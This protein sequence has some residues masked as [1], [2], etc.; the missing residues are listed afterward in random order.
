MRAGWKILISGVII[1]A[2][3]GFEFY[4]LVAFVFAQDTVESG[5]LFVTAL[6]AVPFGIITIWDSS[7]AFEEFD[8]NFA[9]SSRVRSKG[10]IPPDQPMPVVRNYFH[11]VLAALFYLLALGCLWLSLTPSAWG[12][13]S[14]PVTAGAVY[15]LTAFTAGMGTVQLFS[16]LWIREDNILISRMFSLRTKQSPAVP[17]GLVPAAESDIRV[18]STVPVL[19]QNLTEKLAS[20]V[21][22]PLLPPHLRID[23]RTNKDLNEPP[24]AHGYAMMDENVSPPSPLFGYIMLAGLDL[25]SEP[26]QGLWGCKVG[27]KLPGYVMKR[28]ES[29]DETV[30]ML[31]AHE[32][33]HTIQSFIPGYGQAGLDSRRE[34]VADLY[35]LLRLKEFREW[36]LAYPTEPQALLRFAESPDDR[37]FTET[38][39]SDSVALE[40]QVLQPFVTLDKGQKRKPCPY[41]GTASNTVGGRCQNCGAPRLEEL[42]PPIS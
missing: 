22:P 29:W 14:G 4:L 37:L 23:V 9:V 26:A 39:S 2:L 42:G 1:L 40:A 17:E 33:Y 13:S 24:G 32:L 34:H 21:S 10:V 38:A 25:Q 36:R 27:Q 11:W 8:R 18:S 16:G 5:F 19:S 30:V 41:C 28:T 15:G 12:P 7:S 31:L 3:S 35:A 20:R 6:L